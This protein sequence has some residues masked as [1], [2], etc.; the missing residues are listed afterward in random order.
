MCQDFN[1]QDFEQI[2]FGIVSAVCIAMY[3]S[4]WANQI[5]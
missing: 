2:I 5:N 4:S 1:N 3:S